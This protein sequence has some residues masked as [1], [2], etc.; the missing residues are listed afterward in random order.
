MCFIFAISTI[1]TILLA[2]EQLP[3]MLDGTWNGVGMGSNRNRFSGSMSVT[4]E[5]QNPDGSI[6]GKWTI[7]GHKQC[8]AIDETIAGQ[9][10]GQVLTLQGPW[11]DKFPNAGC[12]PPKF[13]LKKS[14]DGRF[15]GGIPGHNNQIKASLAPK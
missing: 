9:F 1:S 2:Q 4:I 10:D 15:E 14:A 8:E 5:K 7:L 13:V 11:R 3:K 12:G 6:E